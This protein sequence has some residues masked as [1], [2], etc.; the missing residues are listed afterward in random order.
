MVIQIG[1]GSSVVYSST[2]DTLH[3][4]RRM[5]YACLHG[6]ISPCTVPDGHCVLK[7]K[8]LLEYDHVLGHD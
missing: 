1:A 2:Y 6:N 4:G 7:T 5:V 8:E 3:Y